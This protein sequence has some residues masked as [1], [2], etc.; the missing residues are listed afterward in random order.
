M[1][2][3]IE[4]LVADRLAALQAENKTLVGQRDTL[5]EIATNIDADRAALQAERDRL[6]AA[7]KSLLYIFD[8]GLP[9]DSIGRRR[10]DEA[11]RALDN[12]T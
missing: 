10:C 9:A 4:A 8:R 3:D 5:H 11:R 6:R 7:L 1:A 2:R 12:Q